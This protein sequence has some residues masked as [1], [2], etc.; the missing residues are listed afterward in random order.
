MDADYS[1]L[2]GVSYSTLDCWGVAREFYKLVFNIELK[3]YYDEIPSNRDLAK[4]LIYTNKGDFQK[5][6]NPKFGD[7]ILIKLFGVESHIAIY[8]GGGKIL[9]TS[10]NNG[11]Y[12]D[13]L[14]KWKHLIVDFYRVAND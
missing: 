5:T 11:C 4:N 2:I 3:R 13:S 1:T 9:H 8:L 7:I 10:K 12:I 6:T 14:A